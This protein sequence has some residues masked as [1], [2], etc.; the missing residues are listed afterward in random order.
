MVHEVYNGGDTQRRNGGKKGIGTGGAQ[1]RREA[2]G[3]AFLD[4][5]ANAQEPDRPHR[6]RD[7]EAKHEASIKNA[8]F[9]KH[10]TIPVCDIFALALYGKGPSIL[11]LIV[12]IRLLRINQPF[13]NSG[14]SWNVSTVKVNRG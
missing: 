3:N 13:T 4:G 6:R 1:P 11:Q 12:R 5:P 8:D 9:L 7:H 14:V 10:A 2:D